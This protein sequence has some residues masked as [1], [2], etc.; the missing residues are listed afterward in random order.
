MVRSPRYTRIP[1]CRPLRSRQA[2]SPFR[3]LSMNLLEAFTSTGEAFVEE[4]DHVR[5]RQLVPHPGYLARSP[6]AEEEGLAWLGEQTFDVV[7]HDRSHD[8]R[9]LH[10]GECAPNVLPRWIALATPDYGVHRQPT[11][12]G[13]N[14]AV[15]TQAVFS[16]ERLPDSLVEVARGALSHLDLYTIC[17]YIGLWTTTGIGKSRSDSEEAWDR[18]CRCRWSV[19]R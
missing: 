4:T 2:R 7:C 15:S 17:A 11:P 13:E 14:E 8:A 9:F 16:A 6:Q 19:R 10:L 5:V 12:L 3:W 18:L 1:F